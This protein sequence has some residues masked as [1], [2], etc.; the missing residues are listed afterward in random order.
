[1]KFSSIIQKCVTLKF[2]S[3]NQHRNFGFNYLNRQS[4]LKSKFQPRIFPRQRFSPFFYNFNTFLLPKNR[5]FCNVKE[6]S[7]DNSNLEKKM[8]H[9]PFENLRKEVE[10]HLSSFTKII[11][12][13][14]QV[15][16]KNMIDKYFAISF[17]LKRCLLHIE[18]LERKVHNIYSVCRN[19]DFDVLFVRGLVHHYLCEL[20]VVMVEISTLEEEIINFYAEELGRG[21]ITKNLLEFVKKMQIRILNIELEIFGVLKTLL[22]LLS[23]NKSEFLQ[24]Y[25][26]FFVKNIENEML[27][28][29]NSTLQDFQ[30]IFTEI[31][32]H[33]VN[34]VVEFTNLSFT[35][36]SLNIENVKME[37]RKIEKILYRIGCFECK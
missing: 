31:H 15:D 14:S 36:L 16:K 5:S 12:E 18:L 30:K 19:R 1:M 23:P 20:Q 27:K 25:Y 21:D 6:T 37:M 32:T 26:T 10:T 17:D 8:D 3:F 29:N 33:L 13:N 24:Q 22:K 34:I 28:L 7:E 2:L 9:I 35:N 4:N 11:S